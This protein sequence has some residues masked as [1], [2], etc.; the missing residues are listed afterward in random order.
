MQPFVEVDGPTSMIRGSN[1]PKLGDLVLVWGHILGGRWRP[2]KPALNWGWV[3]EEVVEFLDGVEQVFEELREKWPGWKVP[4]A[5]EGEFEIFDV[6][7]KI[8]YIGP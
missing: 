6:L 8:I 3:T 4:H 5:Y 7:A 1:I 2:I